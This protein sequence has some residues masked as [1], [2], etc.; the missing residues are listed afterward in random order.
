LFHSRPAARRA[1]KP[2]PDIIGVAGAIAGLGGG[3]AM[4][5]IGAL[6]T[7]ALDQD[8]WL[9]LRAIAGIVLGPAVAAEAG[10]AALPIMVGGLLHLAVAALLGALFEVALG[11]AARRNGNEATP[12]VAGLVYG[13]LIWLVAFFAAIPAVCPLLLQV[14]EPALI[15]QHLVYGAITGLLYSMLRPQAEQPA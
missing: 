10:F 2:L 13:L 5:L 6:L 3:L 8:V 15:I 7:H 12:E 9:Q 14:Y 1:P 4:L 11:R